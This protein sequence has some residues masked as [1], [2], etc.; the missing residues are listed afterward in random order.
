MRCSPLHSRTPS[1]EMCA[2]EAPPPFPV[3][4]QVSASQKRSATLWQ[5]SRSRCRCCRAGRG[6]ARVL[7][8]RSG[9]HALH[10]HVPRPS[11][12][13]CMLP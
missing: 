2:V 5:R 3:T 9:A 1:G 12:A 11:G 13:M 6:E 10:T 8:V 4:R 7:G